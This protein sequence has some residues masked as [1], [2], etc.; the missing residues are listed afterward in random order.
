MTKRRRG[1]FKG[2]ALAL[3]LLFVTLWATSALAQTLPDVPTRPPRPLTFL[4]PADD[5]AGVAARFIDAHFRKVRNMRGDVKVANWT[6]DHDARWQVR[7][8]QE[9]LDDL[10]RQGIDYKLMHYTHA[11][12]PSPVE[13]LG[14]VA[15]VLFRKTH[16]GS[17]FYLSCELASRLHV[18]A[19][20]VRRY[21]V[22]TVDVLS[23]L[24]RE[25]DTSFHYVGLALDVERFQTTKG[26]LSVLEHFVETPRHETCLAPEP[27]DW[28][29]QALRGIACDLAKTHVL[30]T[31][32]TPNY[33]RGHRDHFHIDIRPNDPRFFLR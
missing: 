10:R 7:P 28:R 3:A 18:V 21:D 32:I 26:N 15:G 8:Q 17:P 30:S 27:E 9:C 25:P 19:E 1:G 31:V 12:V 6:I 20:V 14:P 29:A 22:H 11:P 4:A 16:D 23:A 13:L 2:R 33:R 24:R 5:P